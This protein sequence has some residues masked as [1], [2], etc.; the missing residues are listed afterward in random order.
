MQFGCNAGL[1][2]VQLF[3]VQ[4]NKKVIVQ[5]VH[6]MG[7][8]EGRRVRE[9]GDGVVIAGWSLGVLLGVLIG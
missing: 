4:G 8:E 9:G 2:L 3:L 1:L 7:E 5:Y 6:H